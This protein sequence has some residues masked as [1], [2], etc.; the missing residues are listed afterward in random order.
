MRI[1]NQLIA[2]VLMASGPQAAHADFYLVVSAESTQRTLT[3]KQA[4]DLY[5]GRNRVYPDGETARVFDL[6]RSQADREAFYY[7][8]TGLSQAQ[9]N[10]YWSRLQFSGRNLPPEQLADEAA[11]VAAV[12]GN[13]NAIGWLP[14]EP[15]DR[16]LRTL[17]VLK[18]SH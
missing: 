12:R 6:Q 5:M 7:A 14:H 4:V 11:M 15:T 1:F 3:Q 8:L 9:V 2:A 17:L 10:S 18:E 13:P 16:R